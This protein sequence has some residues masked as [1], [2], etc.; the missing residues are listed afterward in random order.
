MHEHHSILYGPVNALWQWLLGITGLA[1]RWGQVEIPDH[2]AMALFV[3]AMIVAI[4][5]PLSGALRTERPNRVQTFLEVIMQSLRGMIE[6]QVG[7][8]KGDR[9][10]YIIGAFTVFIFLANICGL[11]FF[12]TPATA[13]PNTT[14]AL[15]IT[16]FLYYNWVG[17]RKHGIFYLKQLVG[18]VWWLA[19]LFIPIEI[20]SHFARILSLG[21]RLFGNMFGEHLVTGLFLSLIPFVVPM[22]LMALGIFAAVIQTFIFVILTTV[23]IAGAEAEEH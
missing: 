13:D 7:E 11:F 9:Y 6:G 8:G 16:A 4:F 1:A 2:V 10:L 3:L 19:P 22:P 20:I 15:S 12:L 18:P 23:Y 14:F 5:V 21:L 17:F